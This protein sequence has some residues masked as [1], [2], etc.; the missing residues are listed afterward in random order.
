MFWKNSYIEYESIDDIN[1]NLAVKEYLNKIT[2]YS[3]NIAADFK[4]SGSW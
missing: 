3:K 1:K 2:P 4:N